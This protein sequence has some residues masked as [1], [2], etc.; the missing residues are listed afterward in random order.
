M[1]EVHSMEVTLLLSRHKTDKVFCRI[2][3]EFDY[4]ANSDDS[5]KEDEDDPEECFE[6]RILEVKVCIYPNAAKIALVVYIADVSTIGL[7]VVG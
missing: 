6:A 4:R 3:T 7:N 5:E 2:F 1:E